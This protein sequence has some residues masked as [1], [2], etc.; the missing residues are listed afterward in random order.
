MKSWLLIALAC[1]ATLVAAPLAAQTPSAQTMSAAAPDA[2]PVMPSFAS[3]F[4][5]LPNDFVNLIS[6]DT[7]IIL[8]AGGALSLAVHPADK[9]LARSAVNAPFE[10][11]IDPGQ[12]IGDGWVQF[13]GAV[14]TYLVGRATHNAR[15]GALG[16]ELIRAQVVA[17]V[18][19]EGIKVT[20]RRTRPD[21]NH[22]SFPS[23]HTSST[24]ATATV[25]QREFGWKVGV[26]AYAAATAVAVS[27]MTE[28]KHYASDVIFGA[29]IG[30]VAG[31]RLTMH[32]GNGD[33]TL[34][35][36][37]LPGGGG[38]GVTWRPSQP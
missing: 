10:E 28:N 38:V 14:G 32:R 11:A 17:E 2:G 26:P 16:G 15:I 31:R 4:R 13:G 18:L 34:S 27:R 23:G 19:T 1:L 8:G 36:M 35:P 9:R 3:L 5:D 24:F 33:F 22:L 6:P 12:V 7:G 37:A 30:L 29:A 25:L 20:A 21:G